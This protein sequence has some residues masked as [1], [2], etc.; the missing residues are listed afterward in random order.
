MLEDEGGKPVNE[1][2]RKKGEGEK[3][4]KVQRPPHLPRKEQVIIIHRRDQNRKKISKNG[5]KKPTGGEIK[6]WGL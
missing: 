5:K 4:P 6:I 2:K 3:K 1:K